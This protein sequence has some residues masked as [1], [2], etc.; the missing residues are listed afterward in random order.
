[1]FARR[2]TFYDALFSVLYG[3]T[4]ENVLAFILR[5]LFNTLVNFTAGMSVAAIVRTPSPDPS[6]QR[7]SQALWNDAAL[8]PH[9]VKSQ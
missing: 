3:R 9:S 4:E 1:M 8:S 6:G 2:Q 7:T 5:W